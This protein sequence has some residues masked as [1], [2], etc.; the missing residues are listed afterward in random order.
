MKFFSECGRTIPGVVKGSKMMQLY[1]DNTPDKFIGLCL[2][3]VRCKN[4]SPLS[5][6]TMHE[7]FSCILKT[8]NFKIS[9]FC[10]II[11]FAIVM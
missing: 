3:F 10:F 4:D 9:Y 5:A 2:F 11:C 7:V 1:V 6:K 8:K